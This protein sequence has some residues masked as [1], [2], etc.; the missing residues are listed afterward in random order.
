MENHGARYNTRFKLMRERILAMKALWTQEEA[1]ISRRDGQFRPGLVVSEAGAAAASAD[2]LGRRDRLH[3]AP[4]RRVLRRL[5]PAPAARLGRS[6]TSVARLRRMADEAK[7]AIRR[8]CRSRCSAPRPTRPRSAEYR[9]AGIDRVGARNSRREPRRDPARARPLR[10]AADLAPHM[11]VSAQPAPSRRR[12]SIRTRRV[13]VR[14]D[15]AVAVYTVSYGAPVIT[16]VGLK[17][18]AAELGGARSVPALAYSLAWLGA[19]VGGIPMGGSPSA[20]ACAGSS[21]SAR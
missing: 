7:G 11:A 15:R 2:P 10:A 12:N 4:R 18:I 9:E 16:V 20:S 6:A 8:R 14:R 13:V 19:A 5:V 3:A 21:C 17:P 1:A